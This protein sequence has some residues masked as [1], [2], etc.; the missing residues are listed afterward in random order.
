[1]VQPLG[2]LEHV[3]L[4]LDLCQRLGGQLDRLV[5]PG[6]RLQAVDRGDDLLAAVLD[7]HVHQHLLDVVRVL[8]LVGHWR[9]PV[10]LDL[11]AQGEEV[12]PGLGRLPALLVEQ[13][14]VV[15]EP[16]DL[17]GVVHDQELAAVVAGLERHRVQGVADLAAVDRFGVDQLGQ[18]GQ[19]AGVGQGGQRQL[20]G[21][22]VVDHVRGVAA[23]EARLELLAD[24]GDAGVLDLGAAELLLVQLL[25]ELGVVVAVAALEDDDVEGG[26]GLDPEWVLGARL[27]AALGARAAAAAGAAGQ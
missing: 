4:G 13:R 6:V 19:L 14:L 20:L 12:G 7:G 17:E 5:L 8:A 15:P 3:A 27:A 1:V 23:V 22:R 2:A 18:V 21:A 24:V 26:V 11:L 25:V 16:V 10:A 9:D